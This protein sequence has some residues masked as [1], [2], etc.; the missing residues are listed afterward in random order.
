MFLMLDAVNEMPHKSIADY[1]E[2]VGLWRDLT[3]KLVELGNHVIYS[4]RTLDYGAVLSSK[5]LPVPQ[6]EIRGMNDEQVQ[7]F[8]NVYLPEQAERVWV[9]LKGAS[10]LDLFR[11]PFFLK[12]LCEQVE[13]YQTVPKDRAALFTGFVRQVLKREIEGSN[14]LFLPNGLLNEKDHQKIARNTWRDSYDLPERGLLLN[15]IAFLAY[16]MQEKGL[17]TETAQVR[18]DY[19][20]ACDLI[21]HERDADILKAGV[22]LNVLDE[23]AR[24][25][26]VLFFHQL[27]QEFFAARQL[28][29]NPK[30]ELVASAWRADEVQ[31]NLADVLENLPSNDSLP[32]LPQTGW[33][34]TI[35]FAVEMSSSPEELIVSLIETNLPLAARCVY[36]SGAH[37]SERLKSQIQDE[38]ISR[39]QNKDADL[40]A[41]IAAG[42]ALGYLGDPRFELC[43][44]VYGKYLMPPL[45]SIPTDIYPIG[46]DDGLYPN[47]QPS[48]LVQIDSFEIGRF[49][50]TNAEYSLFIESGAYD[51]MQWWESEQARDWLKGEEI[52][53]YKKQWT[54]HREVSKANLAQT[55]E[56]QLTEWHLRGLISDRELT[57]WQTIATISDES[58]QKILDNW[59]SSKQT[60][61]RFWNDPGFCNPAQPV[62]GVSWYEAKAYCAWLSAQANLEFDLPT[63]VEWE[64]AARG[65]NGSIY[66]YGNEFKRNAGNTYEAL[67][68]RT[69][70]VDTFPA[71][72]TSCGGDDFSGNVYEWTNTAFRPYPYDKSDERED[73]TVSDV[74]RVVRG[75]SWL[76][77]RI[78]ARC[79][80]RYQK[81]PFAW[82]ND[83]GFRVV[84][85]R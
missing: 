65:K 40:R 73:T 47:E 29:K 11:T 66:P 60:E 23:D 82:F 35:L 72:K 69:T 50:V 84:C 10:H 13:S 12:L 9:E 80:F 52:D 27:L 5:D 83:H 75:A 68:K 58:F 49:P 26:E 74:R 63:E 59:K 77:N 70:P 67:I 25:E 1:H 78:A 64:A 39:K 36:E 20:A 17:S 53:A 6:I 30:P 44:G 37:V 56:E 3:R 33:E 41:R 18:I 45:I 16:T 76:N 43:S 57:N 48:H 71:G 32:P 31:P 51:D 7:A 79:S 55:T 54:K 8:L 24:Q 22:A 19:D 34:E 38:L 4:C 2:L 81:Y 14:K 42:L 21:Q 85:K 46:S 28:A 62:V 61:P 15:K